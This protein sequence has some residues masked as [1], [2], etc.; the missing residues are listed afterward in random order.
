MTGDR[1][2][3]AVLPRVGGALGVTDVVL[4]P[5]GRGQ[6]RVRVAAAG[7][8]RTDISLATGVLPQPVPAVLGHEG[9]GVV[10]A[11]GPD[12]STVDVGD[13]VLLN[14]APAC[15][16]CSWCERGER[17]LC[18]RAR[19]LDRVPYAAL[20][21]GSP[22]YAGL[23]TATFAEQTVVWAGAVTPLPEG[24]PLV[25][26]AVLGCAVLTGFG[27]VVRTAAVASGETVA[28]VGVGGVGLAV[29]WAARIAGAGRIVA[30]DVRP[31]KEQLARAVGATDFLVS[32]GGVRGRLFRLTAGLGADHAFE[33]TGMADGLRLAFSVTRRG[34]A[35]TILG[36]G[37]RTQDLPI[38]AQELVY[39]GRTVRGCLF[40]GSDPARDLPVLAEYVRSGR[41]RLSELVT[42][43]IA[44]PELPDAIAGTPQGAGRTVVVFPGGAPDA[45]P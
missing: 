26:S 40:G 41:L 7:L 15:G 16:R 32:R 6:V 23:G 24:L 34:G 45:E 18:G 38:S 2:R 37:E 21:D 29:V 36:L 1:V 11:T 31:E 8:C 20:A 33:C 19:D 9:S 28:V 12:V 25:D 30:V 13:P 4:P 35:T 14:W 22:V 39:S 44:L 17:H 5:P 42:G 10:T 3:A 43:R 27:A